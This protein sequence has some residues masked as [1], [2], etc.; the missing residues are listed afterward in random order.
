MPQHTVVNSFAGGEISPR[1]YGRSD[2]AIYDIAVAGMQNF[3][4]TV[5][6]PAIKRSGTQIAGLAAS[7]ASAILPFEFNTTQSYIIEFSANLARFYYGGAPLMSGATQVSVATPYAAADCP[8]LHYWQDGDVLYLC[9]PNYPPA[10][11]NRTGATNFTYTALTLKGGPFQNENNNRSLTVYASGSAV[12]ASITLTANS[13]IFLTGHIGSAFQLQ[14]ADLSAYPTWEPGQTVSV[15]TLWTWEGNIYQCTNA[16]GGSTG[17]TG[18]TPPTHTRGSAWDGTNSTDFSG[19]AFGVEWLYV[20]NQIGQMTI[21]AVGS[22]ATSTN[23]VTTATAT[24][25]QTLPPCLVGSSQASWRWYFGMFSAANVWPKGCVIWNDRLV[26]YTDFWLIGS[27]VSDYLNFN[28]FDDTGLVQEDLSFSYRITGSYA[29]QW[30][31]VDLQLIFGTDRGEYSVG[32]VNNAAVSSSTN[33]QSVKQ[34]HFG[35]VPVRPVQA[36]MRTIFVQRGGRKVRA[37]VFNYYVGRYQSSSESVWC[38]HLVAPGI[39]RLGWQQESEELIWALRADG[40]PLVHAFNP[41]QQEKGWAPLPIADFNNGT[42]KVLDMAIIPNVA[43]ASISAYQT[44]RTDVVYFLVQRGSVVTVE[45]LNDW[46][47]EGTSMAKARFLDGAISYSGSPATN[48]GIGGTGFPVS[49]AGKSVAVLADGATI[50]N[51]P[52]NSDGSIT[53]AKAASNVTAGIF[54]SAFL[55]GLPPKLPN[56]QGGTSELMKRKLIDGVLRVLDAAGLWIADMLTG[57]SREMQPRTMATA[58]DSPQPLASG[59]TDRLLV[60]A[61]HDRNGQWKIE[62]QLPLPAIV[63]QARFAYDVE[64]RP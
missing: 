7:G 4:P 18:Q 30:V 45:Y 21:T 46:W 23:P 52:V 36:E 57:N 19:N 13:P 22:G 29:I 58:M 34:S 24:V 25:T 41:D 1:L 28:T 54:Y 27:V 51:V 8:A 39:T 56:H 9:H 15:G 50:W 14:A 5:E 2:V 26:F 6:G 62:S 40:V 38:R 20:C 32:P 10:S 55:I 60:G 44:S 53:L 61:N 31:A 3:A 47:I 49:W 11:I 17:H 42:A 48:I 63:S 43:D 59:T 12:G 37:A 35:G 33:I 64:Q 16:T